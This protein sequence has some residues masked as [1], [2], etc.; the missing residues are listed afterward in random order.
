MVDVVNLVVVELKGFL[1]V[2]YGIGCN[3]VFF[4]VIEWGDDGFVVMVKLK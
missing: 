1:K 2:E 4:V 3:M